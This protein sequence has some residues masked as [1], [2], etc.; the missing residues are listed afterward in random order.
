MT[1][2]TAG[3][4]ATSSAEVLI[5]LLPSLNEDI[6][7]EFIHRCI[8]EICGRKGPA[9]EKFC[10]SSSWTSSQFLEAT[11]SLKTFIVECAVNSH[12]QR[13]IA[14]NLPLPESQI[15]C[16]MN[17]LAVRG[18]E[19]K[20]CLLSKLKNGT[21]EV[22]TDHDWKV[23]WV[24]GSSSLSSLQE[25][26]LELDLTTTKGDPSALAKN[27]STQ[28]GRIRIELTRDNVNTL[29]NVLEKAQESL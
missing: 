13:Q 26:L 9:S 23:K 1:K 28:H 12:D 29:I 19:L 21:S 18:D 8:D 7:K 4:S 14:E 6:L 11:S 5:E 22:L 17:C 3:L 24:M 16:L 2:T 25:T 27:V 20:H 15:N 10:S